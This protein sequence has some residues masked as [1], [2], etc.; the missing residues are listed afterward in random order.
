MTNNLESINSLV[1][2]EVTQFLNLL[3]H[4]EVQSFLKLF[5]DN[6]L[7]TSEMKI[8][9]RIGDVERALGLNDMA[10]EED[11]TIPQQIEALESRLDNVKVEAS[12]KSS[13]E[14]K[15]KT[16]T[17][18]RAVA[19]IKA[20]LESGKDH[21]TRTQIRKVLSDKDNEE[22]GDARITEEASNPRRDI[23]NALDEAERIC[24]KVRCD[25]KNYGRHERR[26]LKA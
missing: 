20:L 1:S 15:Q 5:V 8:L 24:S 11:V 19:L 21:L 17:G 3:K 14:I 2:P 12:E 10:D 7:V 13:V 9:K 16:K 26:L 22:L 25:K 6:H 4:P 23:S 18:K